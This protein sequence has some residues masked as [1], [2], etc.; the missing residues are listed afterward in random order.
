MSALAKEAA[1]VVSDVSVHFAG[2]KACSDISFHIVKGETLAVIGPNGAGKTTLVNAITGAVAVQPGGSIRLATKRGQRDISKMRPDLIVQSGLVRTFQ[3]VLLIQH[4]SVRENV[5]L[6]R[7]VHQRSG[8]LG[9]MLALPSA[10]REKRAHEA[11]VDEILEILSLSAYADLT[12]S[13]LAYGVRKRIE[14]ARA[15][16]MEP[17]VLLL[18]EPVAGM[19][20]EERNE[21]AVFVARAKE[22]RP[23]MAVLL[24]EHDMKFVMSLAARVL[25]M[26]AGKII[27]IGLPEEIQQNQL[28]LEAYLGPAEE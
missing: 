8:I 4:L 10:M 18:D 13:E 15:L 5:L 9:N 17:T 3:N 16:A 21:M 22:A 6:G 14:L 27:A 2:L 20:R 23:H 11:R 28:V 19:S 7:Y 1:L 12:V 25:A 24:I 26:T